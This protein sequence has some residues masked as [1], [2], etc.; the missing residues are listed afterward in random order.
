MAHIGTSLYCRSSLEKLA[1]ATLN[2]KRFVVVLSESSQ[3]ASR[4]T[5]KL[6]LGGWCGKW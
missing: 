4:L 6:V 3:N 2:P 5:P 1:G